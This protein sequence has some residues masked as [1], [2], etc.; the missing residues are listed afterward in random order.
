MKWI[1]YLSN[2]NIPFYIYKIKSGDAIIKTCN[3]KLQKSAIILHGTIYLSQVFSNQEITP[4]SILHKN[5]I[6]DLENYISYN[7]SYYKISALKE[8]YVMLVSI[9]ELTKY[10]QINSHIFYSL[11]TNYKLTLYNENHIRY[12][13][14]HKNIKYRI[15][16]L[17][18]IL[19]TYFGKIDKDIVN[20]Q[21]KIKME[22]LAILTGSNVNV[23]NKI[24]HTL[25]KQNI[26][27]KSHKIHFTLN[28]KSLIHN[29]YLLN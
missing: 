13:L 9:N 27:K 18:I 8:T 22:D 1:H 24:L 23:T 28:I 16:Q 10:N 6:I 5:N 15:I 12:I 3:H 11:L 19:S 26:L 7:Q 4:I 14:S 21:L 29:I 17:L 25:K 20:I 2:L